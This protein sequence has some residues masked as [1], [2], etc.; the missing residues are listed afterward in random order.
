MQPKKLEKEHKKNKYFKKECNEV[1]SKINGLENR[2]Y[3]K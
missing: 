1:K 3:N 2:K